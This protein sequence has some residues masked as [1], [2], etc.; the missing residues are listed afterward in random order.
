MTDR[1]TSR[2]NPRVKHLLR[3]RESSHR[4]RQGRFPVEGAREVRR[5]LAS[6]WPL[7]SLYYCEDLFRGAEA[8]DL[9]EEAARNDGLECVPMAE[10]AFRRAA[11]REGPD[12]FLAVA[13][14]RERALSDL[15]LSANPLLAVA[16]GLE[17]PGNLGAILRTADATACDALLLADARCDLFNPNAVRASQGA[18]FHLPFAAA[19]GPDIRAFLQTREILPVLTTPEAAKSLFQTDLRGPVAL[20][21]GPEDSGLPEDW[22]QAEGLQV[23]L[24]MRGITDSL[25]VSAMAAVGLF[26]AVR[27]RA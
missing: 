10:E 8:F 11:Y 13:H 12:G 19:D 4:K 15:A 3:L 20:V 18:F 27:Q 9:L 21:L 22:L 7:E 6:R 5:A 14:R 24:P 2:Q 16:V 26:E 1:I 25:N 23:R 17:K